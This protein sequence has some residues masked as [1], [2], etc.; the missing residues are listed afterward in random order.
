[1][2]P[3]SSFRRKKRAQNKTVESFGLAACA[4]HKHADTMRCGERAPP[5]PGSTQRLQPCLHFP[6]FQPQ[7]E[8]KKNNKKTASSSAAICLHPRT[9]LQLSKGLMGGEEK[10]RARHPAAAVRGSVLLSPSRRAALVGRRLR[11]VLSTT[12]SLLSASRAEPFHTHRGR[13]TG[14]SRLSTELHRSLNSPLKIKA[15][16]HSPFF[17]RGRGD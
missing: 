17:R 7:T 10:S 15:L 11:G 2:A 1:M 6:I 5:V 8:G 9:G 16:S 4:R 13:G 14:R 3:S 12:I